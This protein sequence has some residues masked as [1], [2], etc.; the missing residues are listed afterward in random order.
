[1]V[2]VLSVA[3]PTTIQGGSDTDTLIGPDVPTVWY[4]DGRGAGTLYLFLDSLSVEFDQFENLTGGAD[5]DNFTFLPGANIPGVVSGGGGLNLL[6]YLA[7]PATITVN[8]QT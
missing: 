2:K 1:T 8:L 3:N 7:F 4:L 6:E 5:F